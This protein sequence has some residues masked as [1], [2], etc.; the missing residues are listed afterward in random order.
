MSNYEKIDLIKQ[1]YDYELKGFNIDKKP[2]ITNTIEKL[3]FEL[4]R[5]QQKELKLNYS[6]EFQIY[7]QLCKYLDSKQ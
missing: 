7:K 2:S 4:H 6:K 1:I 5:L 3:K